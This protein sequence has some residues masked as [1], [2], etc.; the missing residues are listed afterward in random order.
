MDLTTSYMGMELKHPLVPSASPLSKDLDTIRRLEDAGAAAVVMYSLFEEQIRQETD[1][2]DHYLE[3]GTDSFAEALTYFPDVGDFKRGP[4]E[5]LEHVHKAKEAV[6]IPIIASLNGVTIGGWIDYAKKIQEA[7]A[8]GLELNIYLIPTD[9]DQTGQEVENLYVEIVRQIKAAVSI[10]VA[11]K[12]HPFLSSIPNVAVKLQ[13]AGADA[14]VL[15]NRFFQPDLDVEELEVVPTLQL[16]DFNDMRLPL[17]WT[18]ILYGRIKAD[19][20][21]TSGVHDATGVLKMIMAGASVTM[22]CSELLRG[23]LERIGEILQD[24]ESYMQRKEYESVRQMQGI[25]SQKSCADPA[26]FERA[27]YMKVLESYTALP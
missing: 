12:L 2:L 21:A 22:L 7:G 19:L 16:S 17:R 26:V 23:G 15:F 11:V 1:E 14:L 3:R 18:A 27:N 20:A 25:L 4:E 5:Y 13:E 6:G 8:D 10:P 24:V 9:P